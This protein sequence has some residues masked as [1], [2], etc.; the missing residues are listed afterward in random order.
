MG[1]NAEIRTPLDRGHVLCIPRPHDQVLTSICFRSEHASYVHLGEDR[2]ALGPKSDACAYDGLVVA[3]RHE[4]AIALIRH[5]LYGT[6]CMPLIGI[7]NVSEGRRP[8]AVRRMSDAISDAGAAVLDVHSDGTHNRSVLTTT[9]EPTRL[10]TA[11]TEL[12][13]AARDLIDLERHEGVHPRLGALDVCP[14]VPYGIPMG[15]AVATARTLAASIGDSGIPVFLYG[16]ASTRAQT[17]E[18][19]NLRR[20]GLEAMIERVPELPPDEGPDTI[21]P[22]TGV[23]CVGARGVLI[24]FN[25]WLRSPVAVARAVA[26]AIRASAG[27]LPGLRALGLEIDDQPT[28]QVAMNLTDPLRTGIDD[29]FE[30]TRTVATRLGAEVLATEIVGLVPQRFLPDP[31][32]QAARLLLAPGR[33][34]ES[35][36]A[37]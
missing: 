30:A 22:R 14:I 21:D 2:E 17:R 20:G 5:V 28:S 11:L 36:L 13:K 18:L 26:R 12:A 9:A 19:P 31:D 10:V 27:G 35:A 6:P 3:L 25:V 1:R 23:V 29:A 24:A 34:I 16:A 7:P 8:H 37:G 32:A 15:A 4:D 33:S